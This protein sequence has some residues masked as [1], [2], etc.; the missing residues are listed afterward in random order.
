MDVSV[1]IPT[2]NGGRRFREVLPRIVDQRLDQSYEVVC[3]DSGS[4]DGTADFA[5]SL[6]V[7]VITVE[8]SSFNH[9]LTRNLGI[10]ESQGEI[11]ALTVQDALPLDDNWLAP[12]VKAVID[13]NKVAGAYSRQAPRVDCNPI[14]RDRLMNWSAGRVE[15]KIQEVLSKA[16]FNDLPPMDKLALISFDNV[17]SCVKRSVWEKHPFQ[18]RNFG[19]DVAWGSE[20]ILNGYKIVYEPAS[21]VEHSHNNSIWYE[22]KRIYADHQNLNRLTGLTTVPEFKNIISNGKGAFLH[23]RK[24]LAES[25]MYGIELWYKTARAFIHAYLENIAQYLGANLIRGG[26]SK[27]S[28]AA[29]FDLFL[30]KGV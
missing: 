12:L 23:Y 17:S 30:K 18:K 13:D 15:K 10:K 21:V 6:N 5:R 25:G 8:K 20:V 29:R 11:V 4:T 19:E 27:N 7:K 28:F 24:V 26:E 3:V 14:I 1:V 16:V 22:F 9:G 2:L